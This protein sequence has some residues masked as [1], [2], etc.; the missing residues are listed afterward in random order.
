MAKTSA[1]RQREFVEKHRNNPQYKKKQADRKRKWRKNR[2]LTAK[3][4]NQ[5][6]QAATERQKRHRLKIKMERM[7]NVSNVATPSTSSASPLVSPTCTPSKAYKSAASLGKAVK[8]VSRLLPE[9]PLKK[10]AVIRKLAISSSLFNPAKKV[11][12]NSLA[13]SKQTIE[14]VEQIY[15]RDDISRQAPGMKNSLIVRT[16]NDKNRMQKR[17]MTMMVLEAYK[18]FE[19]DYPSLIGKSKFAELRSKHVL[20]SDQTPANLCLCRYHENV[21]LLLQCL[22]REFSD[23][24]PLKTSKLINLSVCS[25]QNENCM[26]GE[27]A[28]CCNLT[29]FERNIGSKV[30]GD[31]GE[32]KWY[33]WD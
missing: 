23:V 18:C 20:L 28:V 32:L 29:T 24:V 33:S 27:C 6:K 17:H 22:H 7:A 14:K 4:I 5:V 1:Q 13:V 16:G 25:S 8:R 26:F 10:A 12:S 30:D 9:S 31:E 15:Q 3:Q 2:Q 19:Q 11:S 21:N